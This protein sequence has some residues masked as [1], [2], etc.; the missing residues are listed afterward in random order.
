[1]ISRPKNTDTMDDIRKM[2][3]DYINEKSK[4]N[5]LPAAKTIK[6]TDDSKLTG[7]ILFIRF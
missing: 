1:M 5:F 7:M 3:E 2:E 4:P 6:I